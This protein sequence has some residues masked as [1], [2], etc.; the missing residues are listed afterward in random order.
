M[1]SGLNKLS[2]SK[3]MNPVK[4]GRYYCI[5]GCS[6]EG[7]DSSK[8]YAMSA[9]DNRPRIECIDC[10]EKRSKNR[11]DSKKINESNT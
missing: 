8:F 10:H 7:L 4:P 1:E 9:T 11:L 2:G 5:N 6:L 3:R